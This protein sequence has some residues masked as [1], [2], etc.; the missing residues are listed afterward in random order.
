M[1][2]GLAEPIAALADAPVAT[3]LADAL[4][5]RLQRRDTATRQLDAVLADVPDEVH[6]AVSAL[7]SHVARTGAAQER[8]R[9]AAAL[10]GLYT[11][12]HCPGRC[13][14]CETCRNDCADCPRCRD[15]D[16]LGPLWRPWA[17]RSR[18]DGRSGSNGALQR[19]DRA[20]E[21]LVIPL[22][23]HIG[24][25]GNCHLRCRNCRSSPGTIRVLGGPFR[26]APTLASLLV[27][28]HFEDRLSGSVA[29]VT[30]P[31]LHT[32][33]PGAN[34]E[35][36]C[37]S[38]R[39]QR[40]RG[41]LNGS[42]RPGHSLFVLVEGLHDLAVRGAGVRVPLAPQFPKSP[43]IESFRLVGGVFCVCWLIMGD[44]FRCLA[45]T[46]VGQ[47]WGIALGSVRCLVCVVAGGSGAWWLTPRCG[48]EEDDDR[49]CRVGL[50]R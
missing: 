49:E 30:R 25:A 18:S 3:V 19:L 1:T 21:V 4:N 36:G 42:E 2:T 37:M 5:G 46:L 17:R 14:V 39:V 8:L 26:A 7:V 24:G 27:Q 20:P 47:S 31:M 50:G 48:E 35:R 16:F 23:G 6:A 41:E 43:S 45:V 40:H 28:K 33:F 22:R 9:V 15:F 12:T 44:R 29:E 32:N 10:P 34:L 38:S 13:A 11:T